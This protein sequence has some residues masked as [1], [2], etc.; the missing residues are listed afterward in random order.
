MCTQ[1]PFAQSKCNK[2]IYFH[3][4]SNKPMSCLPTTQLLKRV[5]TKKEKHDKHYKLSVPVGDKQAE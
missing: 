1:H 2:V 4:G 3:W 5:D